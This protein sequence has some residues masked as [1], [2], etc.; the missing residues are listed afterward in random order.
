MKAVTIRDFEG[1]EG[2]QV[3]EVVEPLITEDEVLLEM[4]GEQ[5]GKL[6]AD[7]R[8]SKKTIPFVY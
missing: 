8:I 4:D 1:P 2:V 3:E 7:Y 6:A 5:P